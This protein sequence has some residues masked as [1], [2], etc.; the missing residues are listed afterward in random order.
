MSRNMTQKG[1][2]SRCAFTLVELLVVIGI[3]AILISVLLPTL[4]SVRRTANKVKCMTQLREI[5]N[6]LKLYAVDNNNWWPV[7][8]HQADKTFPVNNPSLRSNPA[9]NDYW[10]MFLLKYFSKK[11][12]TNAAGKRLEDFMNT[13][14]WGCP[15]ATKIEADASTSAA[16]FNSGYGMGPYAGYGPDTY[17]GVNSGPAPTMGVIDKGQHWAM[18]YGT[19]SAGAQGHYYRMTGWVHPAEKCIIGDSRS[20]FMETRSV[21]N[22]A[23]IVDPTP[24]GA[25]GY[26]GAASHQFDKWRHSK[27]RGGKNPMS[28]NMLFCDG[29]VA[30]IMSIEDAFRAVRG[31]FPQ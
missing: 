11:P 16:E 14:L 2:K 5:G 22:V 27:A 18:I 25:L 30:E 26:D 24:P 23:G 21:A 8:E 31:H 1:S 29:H 17:L 6:S 20:W 3:I 28:R 15:A 7:V 9:R 4:A 13:P 10:Y 19:V 12:Y